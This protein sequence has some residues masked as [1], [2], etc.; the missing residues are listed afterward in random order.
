MLTF[1]LLCIATL[2]FALQQQTNPSPPQGTVVLEEGFEPVLV[3]TPDSSVRYRIAGGGF[4]SR[5]T[6]GGATWNATQVSPNAKLVAGNAPNA[7]ICWVVGQKGR[8]YRTA[9]GVNW[10]RISPPTQ[11]NFTTVTAQ[12]ASSATVTTADGKRFSTSNGG[13]TWQPVP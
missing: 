9:D 12:N 5:T 4:V 6:D 13:K 1:A 11:S 2:S 10:K 8:I 3:P 7:N